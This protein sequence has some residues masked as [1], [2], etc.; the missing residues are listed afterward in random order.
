MK[1]HEAITSEEPSSIVVTITVAIAVLDVNNGHCI[2]GC[3]Y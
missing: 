3:L 2:S 1:K